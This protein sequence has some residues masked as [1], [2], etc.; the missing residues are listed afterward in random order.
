M[1]RPKQRAGPID[2]Q[3][4]DDVDV[5]LTLIVPLAGVPLA[6]LIG[7]AACRCREHRARDIVLGRD[8]AH[9]VP[10][11]NDLSR[12]RVGDLGIGRTESGFGID[13]DNV[14]G[15]GLHGGLHIMRWACVHGPRMR[16]AG[17]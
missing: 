2:R 4:L 6:V 8:E 7:Q 3:R 1:L 10:L 5:L 17:P 16:K 11:S 13:G 14:C 9:H 12:E 15:G